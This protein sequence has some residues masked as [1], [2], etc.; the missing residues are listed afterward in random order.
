MIL[1]STILNT[2]IYIK[3]L[4]YIKLSYKCSNT[5]SA[6]F[7]RP[8]YTAPKSPIFHAVNNHSPG[9]MT[10]NLPGDDGA[11]E[12]DIDIAKLKVNFSI[13]QR[14]RRLVF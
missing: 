6:S 13:I 12:F 1:N 14:A 4:D 10:M 5:P 3:Q 7:S 9:L 2:L 11:G 8:Y